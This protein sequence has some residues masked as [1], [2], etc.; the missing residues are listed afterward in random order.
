MVLYKGC[1]FT[2]G[3]GS[4]SDDRVARS[5]FSPLFPCFTNPTQRR[6]QRSSW[7]F[8]VRAAS[9]ASAYAPHPQLSSS[10]LSLLFLIHN[11][12]SFLSLFLWP[13]PGIHRRKDRNGAHQ[14]HLLPKDRHHRH[15]NRQ[16][17]GTRTP[18]DKESLLSCS[19]AVLGVTNLF[20]FLKER[21]E[22]AW[23]GWSIPCT[24]WS[25]LYASCKPLSYVY[26]RES[27][28]LRHVFETMFPTGQHYHFLQAGICLRSF[29]LAP[30]FVVFFSVFLSSIQA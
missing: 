21:S 30:D 6:C 5:P 14:P 24:A 13:S 28:W 11:S 10:C 22:R 16:P 8:P 27:F 25:S 1:S 3:G 26:V 15:R 18:K 9:T 23:R 7:V 12:S 4:R 20:R 29:V 2:V 17:S 19:W